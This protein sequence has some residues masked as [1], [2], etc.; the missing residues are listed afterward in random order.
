MKTHK[1]CT[2]K[3]GTDV[4]LTYKEITGCAEGYARYVKRLSTTWMPTLADV[5]QE[6]PPQDYGHFKELV[7]NYGG[8][9]GEQTLRSVCSN[10]LRCSTDGSRTPAALTVALGFSSPKSWLSQVEFLVTLKQ[11]YETPVPGVLEIEWRTLTFGAE[12]LLI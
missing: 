12:S 3:G 4:M 11:R 10:I 6:T 8:A 2:G 7:R 9:N 5:F 1:L